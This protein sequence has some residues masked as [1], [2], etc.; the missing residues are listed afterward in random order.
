LQRGGRYALVLAAGEKVHHSFV[1]RY[2]AFVIHLIDVA[3]VALVGFE[4]LDVGVR[5]LD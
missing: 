4:F 1:I 5:F 3:L 2:S